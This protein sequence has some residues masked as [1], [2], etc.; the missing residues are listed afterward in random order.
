MKIERPIGNPAWRPRVELQPAV[1]S[2]QKRV[3][4]WTV[5]C[6]VSHILQPVVIPTKAMRM[7]VE[8]RLGSE[9]HFT[10]LTLAGSRRTVDPGANH[11]TLG[12]PGRLATSV[13]LQALE[14][15]QGP[16]EEE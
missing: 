11:Q 16:V 5:H 12:A 13:C 2:H 4:R 10:R 6:A 14:R 8:D 7:K 15:P 1:G 9:V 3:H